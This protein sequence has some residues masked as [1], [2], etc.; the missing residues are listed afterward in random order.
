MAE[1]VLGLGRLPQS[2]AWQ[3]SAPHGGGVFSHCLP[4]TGS[5]TGFMALGAPNDTSGFVFTPAVFREGVITD[6]GTMIS[7]LQETA[8]EALRT[9]FRSAMAEYPL[10]PPVGRLDT[11]YNFTGYDSVTVPTVS[12]I[13]RGGAT[14]HLDASSGVLLD[15]CLALWSSTGDEYTGLIGSVSQR[16]IEV[17]YDMPGGKVGFRT[18][19]C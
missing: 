13:F 12:L 2:L 15:G 9:A 3:A 11:C 5:S 8:Y 17:L 14:V 16:T 1:G 10:A 4:P 19:A 7:L 6:S 18:G